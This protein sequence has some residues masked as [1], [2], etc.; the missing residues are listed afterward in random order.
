MKIDTSDYYPVT[1]GSSCGDGVEPEKEIGESLEAASAETAASAVKASA[2]RTM[3]ETASAEGASAETTQ[4]EKGP[5]LKDTDEKPWERFVDNVSH[6][7][8]WVLVPLLMPLY[9]MLVAF[10]ISVL[11]FATEQTKWSFCIIVFCITAV[12]PMLLILM[13]KKMGV[14]QDLGLNGRKERLIP[15]IISILT[16][17][18]SGWFMLAKGAPLW[19]GMF[20][21][22][23]ALAGLVNMIVNLWWKIS[24]HAAAAAGVVA[25][26]VCISREGIPH[27][28]IEVWVAT[29]IG[30]AGLLGS[31]RVW[32][33]R[34]T[35]LQVLAGSAVGFLCVF[36]L[37]LF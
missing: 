13:L 28:H 32:L 9:A 14:V 34:H 35:V 7:L 17:A 2:E 22:G 10:H 4:V 30:I 27:P 20:F 24:A 15:Y 12:V 37:T 21:F 8:S 1:P 5:R 19:S 16:L 31:A 29:A 6:L 25:L 11:Q 33:G 3:A 36:F 26:L 23:G 18:A